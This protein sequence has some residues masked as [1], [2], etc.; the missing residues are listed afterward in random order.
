[1]W[2]IHRWQVNSPQKWP[3]TWK[4]FPL[5]DV[6][7]F[8]AMQLLP[9]HKSGNREHYLLIRATEVL[10]DE[11]KPETISKSCKSVEA[12]FSGIE[13]GFVKPWKPPPEA[14]SLDSGWRAATD[15][16]QCKFLRICFINSHLWVDH[17]IQWEVNTEK[18][19][20]VMNMQN[21]AIMN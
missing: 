13:S 19:D 5:D 2:W 17:I 15:K 6:M 11:T 21:K 18:L 20:I 4:M 10:L 14:N 9:H 3:V 7:I 1:M 12:G 16:C 8:G